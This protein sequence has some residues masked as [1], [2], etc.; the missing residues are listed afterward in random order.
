MRVP[1]GRAPGAPVLL[2]LSFLCACSAPPARPGRGGPKTLHGKP[3][4]RPPRP[5]SHPAAPSFRGR[6]LSSWT[7]QFQGVEDYGARVQA[8][9]ALAA[10]GAPAAPAL[11]KA[12]QDP[13][14]RFLASVAL[15]K[16][17]APAVP[18]VIRVLSDPDE[19]TRL[20]AVGVLGEI[21]PQAKEAVPALMKMVKEGS[22]MERWAA[23][24]ALGNIGPAAKAAVPLVL[25]I[26]E[27]KSGPGLTT[28]EKLRALK[29]L[30]GLLRDENALVRRAAASVLERI[31][32][33][34]PG[35]KK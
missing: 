35:G 27:G 10:I 30:E 14:L 19:E 33:K 22:S 3:G 12:L 18:Q 13:D 4:G 29:V 1:L 32:G 21:G 6:S 2:V 11:A 26:L 24:E 20:A 5:A 7:K 8:S 15:R 23:L 31:R 28:T 25:D 34:K 9:E 16:I 17:G